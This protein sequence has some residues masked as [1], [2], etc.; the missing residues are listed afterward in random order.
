MTL[1]QAVLEIFCSQ[2]YIM[3]Y[4]EKKTEKGDNSRILRILP[5]VNQV[6]CTLDTICDP[7]IMTLVQ[8]VL[9]IHKLPLAYN[10]KLT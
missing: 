6:I 3:A 4:N 1:A 7:N 10:E 2:T 5:N 8:A 9:E